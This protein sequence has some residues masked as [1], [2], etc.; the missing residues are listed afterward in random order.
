MGH[1][2]LMQPIRPDDGP[3]EE[4]LRRVRAGTERIG[5]SMVQ[6]AAPGWIRLDLQARVTVEHDEMT[7]HAV[8]P[9]GAIP[10]FPA[11]PEVRNA[12]LELRRM[13]YAPDIGA[14]LS[15]R[16]TVDPPMQLQLNVN[17]NDDPLWSTPVPG[18]AYRRD[19]QAFPRPADLIS[20]WL[21]GRLDDPA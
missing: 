20:G 19:V 21:R 7:V 3:A 13:M 14:W 18:S 1:S 8:R 17:Y 12:V 11:T 4:N 16:L 6:A 10:S 9:D 2:G 15:L 5:R